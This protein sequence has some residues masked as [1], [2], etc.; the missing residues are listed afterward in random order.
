VR[1]ATVWQPHTILCHRGISSP[2]F[3]ARGILKQI[4]G[5]ALPASAPS[6]LIAYPAFLFI[7]VPSELQKATFTKGHVVFF[8]FRLYKYRYVD[9]DNN[10][11]YGCTGYLVGRIFCQIIRTFLIFCIWPDTRFDGRISS[12]IP[13]PYFK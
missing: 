10:C 11:Y 4:L 8:P 9:I 2:S 13:V 7:I 6:D 12:W 3:M 5:T 1:N